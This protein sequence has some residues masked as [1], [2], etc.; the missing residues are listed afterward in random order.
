MTKKDDIFLLTIRGALKPETWEDSRTTHNMTAGNPEGVAAARALGDLS[1]NVYVPLDDIDGDASEFL[2]MDLWNSHEGFHKFFSDP[3]VQGGGAMIFDGA[4]Q[5]DL[6]SKAGDL[7]TYNLPV[8][9]GREPCCV[10]LVRGTARS[11]EDAQ[12]GF[13]RMASSTINAA[14]MEGIVSHEVFFA[15]P[16]PGQPPSLEI[17]GV[18]VWMDAGGMGRFYSDP[19]HLAPLRSVFSEPPSTSVWT[20]PAGDWVVW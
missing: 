2:I 14:R 3:Q 13:N 4:P 5:R 20:R 11:R 7:F 17:L 8:P 6:W 16:Q 15:L 9:A 19:E 18:D 12:A 10:G 1:H